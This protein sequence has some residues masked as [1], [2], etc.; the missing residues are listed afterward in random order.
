[1]PS[2]T[3]MSQWLD[4]YE[5]E[6]QQA[7]T[8]KDAKQNQ[9]AS[10]H[11]LKA[12]EYL[13]RLAEGTE[14]G[15]LRDQRI[16]QAEEL[17]GL[18]DS[19]S[20]QTG[21]QGR[22]LGSDGASES[23]DAA[24][25]PVQPDQ[26][27]IAFDDI[28]GLHDVKE[29][30]RLRM[31]YPFEHPDTAKKHGL[32]PGGGVLLYGPPG[33]GKTMIARATAKELGAA[34]FTVKPSE[35]MSKWVGDA[36]RRIAE[37]FVEAYKHERSVI[38][39]DEIEALVPKRNSNQSTVMQRVVPQ[40][41]AELDGFDKPGKSP[42]LF[43]GATNEPWMI[44]DAILRPGRFDAKIYVGLPDD[45]AREW[46]IRS[47]FE[48]KPIGSDVDIADL[49]NRTAGFS[50]ADIT[51]F[52]QVLSQKGFL[53]EL[54]GGASSYDADFIEKALSMVKPSVT[55]ANLKRY[56]KWIQE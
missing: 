5:D 51:S 15:R 39:I 27:R 3:Q 45:P 29:Q 32:K 56:E 44:D 9:Q 35:I 41:L 22:C 23:E 17:L 24:F 55:Q 16:K 13:Y 30:I 53:A 43:I 4:R 12:A 2:V 34:F 37:L 20:K 49:V 48:G 40:F 14:Q 54:K 50:G 6:V 36:E 46:M 18:S 47:G 19:L 52:F 7:L 25:T 10:K 33:T 11:L 26:L 1:M 8:A 31:I 21:E 28:A 38:F 42:L